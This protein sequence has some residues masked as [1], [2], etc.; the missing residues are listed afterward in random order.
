MEENLWRLENLNDKNIFYMIFFI[1]IRSEASHQ[2]PY[3]GRRW[4]ISHSLVISSRALYCRYVYIFYDMTMKW[5]N[6]RWFG[7]GECAS[8]MV[9][10][11]TIDRTHL[12]SRLRG[13]ENSRLFLSLLRKCNNF[14]LILDMI[15]VG[16]QKP[17]AYDSCES[18]LVIISS[19]SQQKYFIFR[20]RFE[21]WIWTETTPFQQWQWSH[22]S[23]LA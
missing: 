19:L 17:D 4:I 21:V 10:Y 8:L 12:S 15:A 14:G 11:E 6:F 22:N 5:I 16:Q 18:A 20:A 7:F 9:G 2:R 13:S 23:S 3:C 1:F